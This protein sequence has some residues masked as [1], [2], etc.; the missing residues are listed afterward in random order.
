MLV[1]EDADE[2]WVSPLAPQFPAPGPYRMPTENE[3]RCRLYL[4]KPFRDCLDLCEVHPDLEE[5]TDP[6]MRL[7]ASSWDMYQ[8]LKSIDSDELTDK[9]MDR[10]ARILHFIA[11]GT[12]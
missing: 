4:E 6:T 8:L 1:P 10:I 3:R 11:K 9:E 7:L 5:A 2:A 12:K